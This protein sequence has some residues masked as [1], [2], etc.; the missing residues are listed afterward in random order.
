MLPCTFTIKLALLQQERPWHRHP[1]AGAHL[2]TGANI[3]N[4]S[5][6]GECFLQIRVLSNMIIS[7]VVF[8]LQMKTVAEEYLGML[9]HLFTSLF[10]PPPHPLQVRPCQVLSWLYLV[11][12]Q[13]IMLFEVSFSLLGPM[14]RCS[15]FQSSAAR[16]HSR[17][18]GCSR[19]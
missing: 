7:A 8:F 2:F 5:E 10:S 17:C 4:D 9:Q 19:V 18:R 1:L 3:H 6:K 11:L 12:F 15:I 13:L 16:S 14:S